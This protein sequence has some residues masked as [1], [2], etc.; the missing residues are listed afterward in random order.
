LAVPLSRAHPRQPRNT[1]VGIAL[2]IYAGYYL[3]YESARTWVQI[4]VLPPFPGLWI[5]PASLALVLIVALQ[6]PQHGLRWRGLHDS[7]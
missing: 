5:A 3:F 1:K 6:G 4:G 2:L 7:T